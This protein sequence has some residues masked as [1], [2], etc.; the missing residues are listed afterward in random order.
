[1]IAEG[2]APTD[3]VTGAEVVE[4]PAALVTLTE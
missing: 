4:Q 1:M 2:A 3:T